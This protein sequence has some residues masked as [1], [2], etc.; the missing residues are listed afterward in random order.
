LQQRAG[1]KAFYNKVL[2]AAKRPKHG[3]F[4]HRARG[5]GAAQARDAARQQP[6]AQL[7]QPRPEPQPRPPLAMADAGLVAEL[8]ALRAEVAGLRQAPA[9][10]ASVP[11]AAPVAPAFTLPELIHTDAFLFTA[12]LVTFLVY[13]HL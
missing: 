2:E 8:A 5:N 9:P 1:A 13:L 12:F 3:P 10:A 6:R 4:F 7:M 11:A